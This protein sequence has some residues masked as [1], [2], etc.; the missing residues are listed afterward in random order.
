MSHKKRILLS[1]FFLCFWTAS[2]AAEKTNEVLLR[3][4]KQESLVRLVLEGQDDLIKNTN[5]ATSLA[6]VRVDFPTAV[7]IKKQKDFLFETVNK[8]RFLVIYLR[9]VLDVRTYKLTAPARLVIDLR[10]APA[11]Q[12]ETLSKLDVKAPQETQPPTAPTVLKGPKD[13]AATAQ[14]PQQPAAQTPSASPGSGPSPEKSRRIKL[15]VIDPGHGGFDQGI[16]LQDKREK[17][18]SLALAKD[19]STVIT[20]KGLTVFL[21]RKTDQPL[22]L[23]ERISFASSRKPDLFI[24][25][26]A[27]AA[28]TWAIYTSTAEEKEGNADTAIR[29]YNATSKQGRH[30]EKSRAIARS[31]G[32]AIRNE[33]KS[34]VLLRELPLPVLTSLDSPSVIIEYPLAKDI[35]YDQKMRDRIIKALL[36]GITAYEQ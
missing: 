2:F 16:V 14:K 31:L 34:T 28:D 1:C 12:K 6:L 15:W 21:T 3:S 22:S 25:L 5:I 36:N 11:Q 23:Q 29:M 4:G 20:K 17:D 30:L 26:H 33:F 19:L 9:D 8:D 7:E 10:T 13:T 35:A 32:T 18:I 24:S 27:S